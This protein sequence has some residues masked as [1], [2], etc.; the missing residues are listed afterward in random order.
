MEEVI[1]V[2]I[3][4]VLHHVETILDSIQR[5]LQIGNYARWL[6]HTVSRNGFNNYATK[7][8]QT[9]NKKSVTTTA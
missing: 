8:H 9:G 6:S 2:L 4:D 1:V 5:K 7:M 3:K